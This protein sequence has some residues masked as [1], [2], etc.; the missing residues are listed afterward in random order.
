MST[1]RLDRHAPLAIAGALTLAMLAIAPAS[2]AER[3][4]VRVGIGSERARDTHYVDAACAQL[5]PPALFGCVEGNDGR[6]IGAYGDFGRGVVGELGIGHR[7]SQR[8]RGELLLTRRSGFDFEGQANFV[9]VTGEQPVAGDAKSVAAFAVGFIDF[10]ERERWRPYLGA[11]LGYARNTTDPVDYG[12]PG[13][14]PGALTRTQG[15]THTGSAWMATAGVAVQLRPRLQ[16]DVGW[17][18]TDLGEVRTDAGAAT[19]VRASGEREIDVGATHA[20]L[21]TSGGVASLRWSF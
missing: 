12:F 16:L 1:M 14:A 17:R 19:I 21:R 9:G 10:R 8:L 20:D 4:Y 11:G 7:F 3:G 5:Q 18:Y 13:L 6:Q 15:G 2:A